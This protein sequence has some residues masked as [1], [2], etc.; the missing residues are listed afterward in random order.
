VPLAL[1]LCLA[2]A[3]APAPSDPDD[4]PREPIV[5]VPVDIAGWHFAGIPL[6]AFTSDIGLTIGAAVFFYRPI[7]GHPEAQSTATLG[8][9][10]STRGPR[11]ADLSVGTQ[12]LLGTPLQTSLNVH[13]GDDDGMPY[14]GEGARLGGL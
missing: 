13:V 4:A 8:F 3:A 7:E 14:W 5:Q 9:S 6:V 12:R 2:A 10:Y 1:L 11:S